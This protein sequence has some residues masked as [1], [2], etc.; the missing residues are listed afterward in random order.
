MKS[1]KLKI[2]VAQRILNLSNDKLLKKISDILDE[3]NVIGY[4][5]EGDPI[6]HEEYISDITHALKQFKEGT[7]ET[8]TSEEVRQRIL[9]K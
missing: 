1:E 9:N 4:N 7:L 5:G 3:E 8:Y 6:S 2:N